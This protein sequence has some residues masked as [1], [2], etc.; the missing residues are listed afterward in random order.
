D[1]LRAVTRSAVREAHVKELKREVMRAEKLQSHFADR[2]QDLAFL[3]H[4]T[5]VHTARVQQHLKT[6]PEYLKP[7]SLK[8]VKIP[9][10][11]SATSG[12]DAKTSLVN[13]MREL[14]QG[15]QSKRD[16]AKARQRDPLR[17]FSVK[18]ASAKRGKRVGK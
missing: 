2:P 3:R 6:I 7:K 8:K 10:P 13:G 16:K 5:E 17:S 4:D 15:A 12:T 11:S 9:A 1:A 18:P 14:R